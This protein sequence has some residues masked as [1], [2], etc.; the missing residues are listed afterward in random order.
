MDILNCRWLQYHWCLDRVN[1]DLKNKDFASARDRLIEMMADYQA[2]HRISESLLSLMLIMYK[3]IEKKYKK[4]NVDV[5][6][7]KEN[8]TA[9]E[10]IEKLAS[11]I[12]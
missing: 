11:R 4:Y 9:D 8:E 6:F 5:I 10:R 2:L 7:T 1:R 12:K 3:G